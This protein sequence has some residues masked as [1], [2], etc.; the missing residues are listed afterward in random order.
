M[1]DWLEPQDY[2]IP[3]DLAQITAHPLVARRLVSLGLTG[4]GAAAAFLDPRLYVP[5][6][7]SAL[8]DLDRAVERLVHAVQA[9]ERILVWGD[10]DVDGQTST[11]LLVSALNSLGAVV[12]FHIPVRHSESHG[13]TLPVLSRYI[14]G[15]TDLLL[16]CDTGITAHEAVEYANQHG[17]DVIITDHH[18]LPESLPPALAAVN[19]RRLPPEHPLANLPGVG[20]AYKLVEGLSARLDRPDLPETLLDLV[21]LGL[22]ADLATLRGDAR[23]LLQRGLFALRLNRRLGLGVLFELAGVNPETLTEEQIGFLIAPR[24]N[25]IGRLADANPVVE[26]LTTGDLSRARIL[27][28]QIEGLNAQRKLLTEQVFQGALSQLE[29]EPALLEPAALVLAH[30]A[31]P[32]GVIGIVASRLVE[33]FHKPAILLSAPEGQPARGSARS[34]EGIH[35]TS[36]IASQRHLLHGF[37]GHPMAAGLAIDAERIP[38]FRLELSRHIRTQPGYSP[39]QLALQIDHYLPLDQLSLEWIE[40]L[41]QLAPFGPGNPPP[42]LASRNLSLLN[43]AWLGRGDEHLRLTVADEQSSTQT[44]L[45]WNADPTHLPGGRF[46]L[47]YAAHLSDYRGQ[48]QLTLTYLDV[49][50]VEAP[51]VTFAARRKDL[52]IEDYRRQSAPLAALQKEAAAGDLAVWAEGEAPEKLAARD[53]PAFDRTRLPHAQLL[54]VWTSPPGPAELRQALDQVSPQRLLLFAVDPQLDQPQPFL[55]RLAG[56]VKHAL[57][58]YQGQVSLEQLAA[59]TAQRPSAVKLGLVWLAARGHIIINSMQ[60]DEYNLTSGGVASAETAAELLPQLAALLA[61]SAAYRRH[62]LSAS[63]ESLI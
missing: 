37:G 50:Q 60:G 4:A 32:A 61:E 7:P 29:R 41:E 43:H 2:L 58:A 40:G 15:G 14:P 30:P 20:A 17:V 35:I 6:P 3:P 38:E 48:R 26:L 5:A 57:S 16:T 31:W 25:A 12:D 28:S 24:L 33:R 1:P 63:P 39:A 62:Y 34:V 8:P 52:Q 11:T 42:V 27:A 22:V 54:A 47:A 44:V 56:L 36:A 23:Y 49:R 51:P 19:P 18:E 45:W 21:A 9:H 55:Q 10:F 59:L 53:L 46:D 13:I